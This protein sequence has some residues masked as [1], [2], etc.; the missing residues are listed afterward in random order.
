[1][2]NTQNDK[3]PLVSFI[4]PYY[5]VPT[6]MLTECLASI[7]NLTLSDEEREVIL[8]DDGSDNSPLEQIK[9]FRDRIIYI[10]TENRGLGA[11]RNTAL[12]ICK[13]Q[14]VQF[15]DADDSLITTPYN[16]CLDIV[17]YNDPDMVMFNLTEN[18]EA[19][20]SETVLEVPQPV[21]GAMYMRH[22]NIKASVCGYIFKKQNLVNLRFTPGIVHEDEEFTP[23]LILR[24]ERIF[25]TKTEA[26]YYR[27]RQGSI[28]NSKTR[29]DLIKRLDD[30]EQVII[31]LN[32][33]LPSLP[34]MDRNALQ[35]RVDQL[36]MDYLYNII[37]LTK[38]KNELEK[39]ITRLKANELFPLN[40]NSY[41][42]KYKVFSKLINNKLGRIVLL[43]AVPL[44]K[45]E[46]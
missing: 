29:K 30:T 7:F 11:A 31:S 17:R 14:Y 40:N 44:M 28:T 46:K 37:T 3:T 45:K 6:E 24:C 36:S 25:D 23:L 15:I 10:R 27:E 9:E 33:M 4:I 2:Q 19:V 39:R 21:D 34:L 38:S 22:N 13:G 41:T 18:R 12:D 26:Y 42:K 35:R 8:I 5:N 16:H 43:L 32:R 1:M 20:S